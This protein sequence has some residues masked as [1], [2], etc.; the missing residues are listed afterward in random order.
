LLFKNRKFKSTHVHLDGNEYHNCEFQKCEIAFAG[1][2]VV[3]LSD[4][5]FEECT[6]VFLGAADK[7]IGFLTALYTQPAFRP[8]VEATLHNIRTGNHPSMKPEADD[9]S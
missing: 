9:L 3:G 6:W 5:H 8:L 7:T 1:T 4:C 2:E